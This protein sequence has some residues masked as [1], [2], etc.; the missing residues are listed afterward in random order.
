MKKLLKSLTLM[1]VVIAICISATACTFISK[2]TSTDSGSNNSNSDYSSSTTTDT[3]GAT[4]TYRNVV[5]NAH[6]GEY[7]ESN[8]LTKKEAVDKVRGSS[9]AIN[10][11]SGN[12]T[13]AGS[14]VIVDMNVLDDSGNVI[15]DEDTIYI[16]TCHHVINY[17]GAS[18]V[19]FIPKI[20][21][22]T[23]RTPFETLVSYDNEDYIFSGVI[24][25]KPSD[26]SGYA[27]TLVGGDVN[28][29]VALL[30]VNLSK[31]ARSGNTLSTEEKNTIRSYKVKVANDK[32]SLD[33]GEELFSIGNPSGELP[34][35]VSNI[36]TVSFPERT[37][38]VE[39]IGDMLLT[40]IDITSNQ[41]NSGGGLYNLYGDLVGIT[42]A[43]NTS[44]TNL[45]FAIP[46]TLTNDNTD[47]K[48]S[49]T[50][51]HGFKYC[52]E[53]LLATATS[54]NYGCVPGSRQKLGFSVTTG[55]S[56]V[57]VSS[58]TS[59]GLAASAG[60]RANDIIQTISVNGGTAQ[61]VTTVSA[62]SKIMSDAS[63][64][65]KI[66]ISGQHISYSWVGSTSYE[67][68]TSS[69]ITIMQYWFCYQS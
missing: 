19:I 1:F 60:L 65:D 52:A 45:N 4:I 7:T 11:T 54:T 32:Y 15:D 25:G 5:F 58:V 34:G 64:G 46:Y 21:T 63:I 44:Y 35:T 61:S 3:S 66:V 12:S 42:N 49:S 30:K 24:G 6:T 69:A 51:N 18:V 67:S 10:I 33:E 47:T 50:T 68:F 22:V 48:W 8:K 17:S 14:G 26:N 23:G 53:K 27:V 56:G 28:S 55:N 31:K 38:A 62:F 40:Q 57:L 16:L 43:G 59:G 20:D 29:D 41:G 39:N 13:S 9:V 37:I 36:G 2:D